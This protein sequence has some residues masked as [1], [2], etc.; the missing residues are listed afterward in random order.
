M[1]CPASPAGRGAPSALADCSSRCGVHS[2]RF[3]VRARGS[4]HSHACSQGGCQRHTKPRACKRPVDYIESSIYDAFEAPRTPEKVLDEWQLPPNKSRVCRDMAKYCFCGTDRHKP[5]AAQ[6]FSGDWVQCGVCCLW[7][8]LECT[9]LA[10]EALGDMAKMAY[11]C[12]VCEERGPS[13]E[14]CEDA[15]RPSEPMCKPVWEPLERNPHL[16]EKVERN[17]ELGGFVSAVDV[18]VAATLT[19][20]TQ[21]LDAAISGKYDYSPVT[22]GTVLD[23]HRFSRR[24]NAGAKSPA[25]DRDH[26]WSDCE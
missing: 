20:I 9:T 15:A 24:Y 6:G 26:N 2:V 16:R 5:G 25:Y 17:A 12:H 8:H 3:G 13:K 19:I 7:C 10:K 14:V 23:P 4:H 11:V 22:F 21:G 1:T 18:N